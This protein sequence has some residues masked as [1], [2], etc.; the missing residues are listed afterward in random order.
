MSRKDEKEP[1]FVEAGSFFFFLHLG[2]TS[3]LP[4]NQSPTEACLLFSLGSKGEQTRQS[5]VFVHSLISD[6]GWLSVPASEFS[7][8]GLSKKMFICR[9]AI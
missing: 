4:S 9:L 5:V 1:G 8:D 2:C 7:P 3:K 6:V